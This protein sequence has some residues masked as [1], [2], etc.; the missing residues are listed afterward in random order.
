METSVVEA[1]WRT[2]VQLWSLGGLHLAQWAGLSFLQRLGLQRKHVGRDSELGARIG[3]VYYPW[4]RGEPQEWQQPLVS[5][6][7]HGSMDGGL[8]YLCS[9]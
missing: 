1:M 7:C 9:F 4:G 3:P 8:S 5:L 2:R 6:L